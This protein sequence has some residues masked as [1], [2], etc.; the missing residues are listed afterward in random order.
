MPGKASLCHPIHRATCPIH[1]PS[2]PAQ[3]WQ[4][5]QS[6]PIPSH[7]SCH[8]SSHARPCHAITSTHIPS[9]PIPSIMPSIIP[10][11]AMYHKHS[12]SIA[13]RLPAKPGSAPFLPRL[14]WHCSP[15]AKACLA[16]MALEGKVGPIPVEGTL[17]AADRQEIWDKTQC[18]AAVRARKNRDKC[19]T[20]SGPVSQLDEGPQAC[21][22][23]HG[24]KQADT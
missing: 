8:P 6:N 5:L 22:G 14:A 18:R 16:E 1:H 15:L 21:H 12:H 11:H 3:H 7:P 17:T 10:C 13:C 24:E 2:S 20:I 9:H 23:G 19:L 4:R